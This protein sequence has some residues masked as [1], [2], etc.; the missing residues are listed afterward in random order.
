[1]RP[2]IL[3]SNDDGVLAPGILALRDIAQQWGDV[4][5]VAPDR[6]RSGCGHGLTLRDTLRAEEIEKNRFAVSGTPADCVYLGMLHLCERMPD[7]V[8]SGINRGYNLGTDIYYSGTMG[9]AREARMRGVSALA[10][11]VDA[12]GRPEQAAPFVNEV[13]EQMLAQKEKG[14]SLLNLNVPAQLKSEQMLLTQLGARQYQQQ[15]EERKDL[16]GRSYYWIGGPPQHSDDGPG[17]D[18]HAVVHGY[19]SLSVLGLSVQVPEHDA[20]KARLPD[21]PRS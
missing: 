13:I 14:P 6:E 20:W 15:V 2:L 1:M 11:S 19:A 16:A 17:Y 7:L 3:L 9:A 10:I 12:K 5:V 21:R 8:L 4:V 18:T